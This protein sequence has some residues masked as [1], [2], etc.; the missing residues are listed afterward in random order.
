MLM[1]A[2][3]ASEVYTG[4][5]ATKTRHDFQSE[6]EIVSRPSERWC[7]D[8]IIR[9][10]TTAAISAV[11]VESEGKMIPRFAPRLVSE[12]LKIRRSPLS[13]LATRTIASR[14]FHVPH[15]HINA[16]HPVGVVRHGRR[17]GRDREERSHFDDKCSH[18]ANAVSVG[19]VAFALF[20]VSSTSDEA[21]TARFL[22]AA[23]SGA[24][25]VLKQIISE[26][27][28]DVNA[29]HRLGWSALHV[30]AV[31]GQRAAVRELLA[32]GADPNLAEEYTNIYH[33][34]REK[35]MHSLDVMV[36]REE[37][38][39]DRL[40]LRANFRGCTPLHYA[41]LAED[42]EVVLMLLEAGADPV[43]SNDY[44][45]TPLDYARLETH[46]RIM[47]MVSS[48]NHVFLT[49]GTEISRPS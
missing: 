18:R 20:D 3:A 23:Q 46:V 9:T 10:A 44:G 15:N 36:A 31:N 14:S 7:T 40:N 27:S 33:T 17:R 37:E 43:R 35:G 28:L 38:F 21:K 47:R 4:C 25:G 26:K 49:T 8:C 30:A 45:R 19:A 16:P 39:S 2:V 29:R 5:G 6:R 1:D 41:V 22:R 42:Y 32:A 13:Q 12:V 34:A 11:H 24:L 48:F